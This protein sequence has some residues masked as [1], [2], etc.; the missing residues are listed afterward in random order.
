VVAVSFVL[1]K[2]AEECCTHL[3]HILSDSP[4][5]RASLDRLRNGA[6]A[7][8]RTSWSEAWTAEARDALIPRA[9]DR[10]V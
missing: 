9:A 10:Q 4:S 3:E 8:A 1:F 6:I 2:T 7:S 5:A